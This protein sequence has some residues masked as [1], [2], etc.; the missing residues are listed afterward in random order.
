MARKTS[1]KPEVR[2]GGRAENGF[3]L[4]EEPERLRAKPEEPASPAPA[5]AVEEV[6]KVVEGDQGFP[7]E[8]P[9][10]DIAN[11]V[12]LFNCWLHFRNRIKQPAHTLQRPWGMLP[13]K[14]RDHLF[15]VIRK[16]FHWLDNFEE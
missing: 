16:T 7:W 4:V 3:S 6:E 1:K 10:Y 9:R 8:A 14:V 11:P 2:R 13:K 12:D 5:E 15:D